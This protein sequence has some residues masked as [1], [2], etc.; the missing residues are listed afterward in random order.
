MFEDLMQRVYEK[1]PT[2]MFVRSSKQKICAG[3]N[4]TMWKII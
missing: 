4:S 2:I 1:G 3:F